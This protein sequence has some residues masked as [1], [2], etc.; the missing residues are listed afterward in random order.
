MNENIYYHRYTLRSENTLNVKSQQTEHQGLIVK[1]GDGYGCIHPW[2]VFGDQSLDQQLAELARGSG[3]R[4]ASRALHC[5][6]IDGAA[7]RA[8]VSLLKGLRVPNSHATIVGGLAE[9]EEAVKKGFLK[10]K[11]KAG[12]SFREDTAKV[13]EIAKTFPQL[14]LRVDFNC[15]LLGSEVGDFIELLSNEAEKA[16][17]FL[18]DP[19][20]YKDNCWVGLRNLYGIRLAMDI[21]VESIDALYTYAVIKPAKNDVDM[22]MEQSRRAARKAV[23]TSY[24]DHPL[25]QAFAAYEAGR[26]NCQYLGVL[27]EAGLMTHGLFEPD[28]FITE[29]GEV[30]PQWTYAEGTGLGFDSLLEG[31]E[32]KKLV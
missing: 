6:K 2:Q 16:I 21:G 15:N 13:N 30:T 24:M 25:G 17:D 1:V 8:G 29:L 11:L 18:E 31:L 7:R 14:K 10:I 20:G 12:G 32:W 26:C 19:C 9:V 22:V 23:F 3:T 5:A 4:L 27:S 28:A